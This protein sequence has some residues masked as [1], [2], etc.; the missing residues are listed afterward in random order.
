MLMKAPHFLNVAG[1]SNKLVISK[2]N[3]SDCNQIGFSPS[4][5]GRR[6]GSN[7]ITE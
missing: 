6:L 1:R 7:Q 3:Y 2:L 4:Q 5:I